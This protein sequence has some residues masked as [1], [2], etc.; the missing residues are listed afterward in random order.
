MTIEQVSGWNFTMKGRS[1]LMLHQPIGRPILQ[2][3]I[4]IR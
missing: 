2:S 3:D 4:L 1:A